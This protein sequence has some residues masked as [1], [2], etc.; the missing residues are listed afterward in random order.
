[1]LE[2]RFPGFFFFCQVQVRFGGV[3]YMK[4]LTLRRF[5]EIQHLTSVRQAIRFEVVF[6]VHNCLSYGATY[7]DVSSAKHWQLSLY[8]RVL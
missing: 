2:N 5:C 4:S 1:M 7:G 3:D 6:T 8:L